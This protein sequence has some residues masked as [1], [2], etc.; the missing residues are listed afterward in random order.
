MRMGNIQH[1]RLCRCVNAVHPHAYG[2]HSRRQGFI[3]VMMGSSPCVWGTSLIS[4]EGTP[5]HRFIPMRMGN[6]IGSLRKSLILPVHPHAYGEHQRPSPWLFV[7]FGSSPCVWGTLSTQWPILHSHRFIPMRMGNICWC[8]FSN[9]YCTVHPHAYGEHSDSFAE[10][11]VNT[12]SSPCVWGT[13]G[14]H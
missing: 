14:L 1:R 10:H 13:C 11:C 9:R 7:L 6:I 12:G 3:A 5:N 4:T 8:W 2:E